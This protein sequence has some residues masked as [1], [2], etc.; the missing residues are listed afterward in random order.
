MD[1]IVG[2]TDGT[3]LLWADEGVNEMRRPA[4]EW[5][6]GGYHHP[7]HGRAGSP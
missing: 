7:L 4:R 6:Q 1:K 2:M 5:S 3:P